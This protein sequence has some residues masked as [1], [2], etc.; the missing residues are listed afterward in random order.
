MLCAAMKALSARGRE[1]RFGLQPLRMGD[2]RD[3]DPNLR[4]VSGLPQLAKN[5]A[6]TA[7]PGTIY[8]ANV[9]GGRTAR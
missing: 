1:R 9:S 3:P 4:R 6:A 8:F 7:T 2:G 5:E